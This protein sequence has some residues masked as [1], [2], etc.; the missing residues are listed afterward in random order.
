MTFQKTY[1]I[2]PLVYN[3]NLTWTWT[4]FGCH[5]WISSL[6]PVKANESIN[7]RISSRS[8]SNKFQIKNVIETEW[9]PS[10][11][12]DFNAGFD[13]IQFKNYSAPNAV[14]IEISPKVKAFEA[15]TFDFDT[16]KSAVLP[17]GTGH[18]QT[19]EDE[20]SRVNKKRKMTN[21]TPTSG[22]QRVKTFKSN[23]R[24]NTSLSTRVCDKILKRRARSE[25]SIDWM[26]NL[27]RGQPRTK[28]I[29]TTSKR[30][31]YSPLFWLLFFS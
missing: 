13:N 2:N 5:Y 11:D 30:S 16:S 23:N 21:H 10:L 19:T 26:I 20:I 9:F 15:I 3:R 8:F 27:W 7:I 29:Q 4:L 22:T 31:F 17:K 18:I 1:S 24:I 25:I 12:F 14:V 28:L 6:H